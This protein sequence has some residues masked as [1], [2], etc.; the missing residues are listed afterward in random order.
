MVLSALPPDEQPEAAPAQ[1]SPELRKQEVA[2]ATKEPA[3]TLIVDT[4]NTHLYYILVAGA[5][6]ATAY[7][8][9]AT[10]SPGPA[11]RKYRVRPNGRI[12]IRRPR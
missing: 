12:G 11:C 1:L 2:Y 5:R 8:L 4:P 10:A 6:S 9:A 7:A 3:G